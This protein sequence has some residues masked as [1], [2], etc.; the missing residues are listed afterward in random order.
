M[1][2]SE[3]PLPQRKNAISNGRKWYKA[4]MLDDSPE[5]LF[6]AEVPVAVDVEVRPEDHNVW[7]VKDAEGNEVFVGQRVRYIV[8]AGEEGGTSPQS[9]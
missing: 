4:V 8:L 1:S 6:E 3:P 5:V 9:E 7:R 2:Y